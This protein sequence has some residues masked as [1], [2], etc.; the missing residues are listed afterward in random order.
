MV[1]RRPCVM[2]CNLKPKI[3]RFFITSVFLIIFLILNKNF[4]IKMLTSK[5][6]LITIQFY[7]LFINFTHTLDTKKNKL[8]NY[9]K[10]LLRITIFFK[11]YKVTSDELSDD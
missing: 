11:V 1:K 8:K 10:F 9:K 6:K 3:A 5:K 7:R 2:I 4:K